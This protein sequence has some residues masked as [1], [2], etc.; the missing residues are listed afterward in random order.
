MNLNN[1][2]NLKFLDT[3]EALQG[4]KVEIH[5]I[6]KIGSLKDLDQWIDSL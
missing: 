4:K 3:A 5:A 1:D 6:T 2:K